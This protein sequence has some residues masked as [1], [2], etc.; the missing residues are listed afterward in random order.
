MSASDFRRIM[1]RW[2][3]GTASIALVIAALVFVTWRT[4]FPGEAPLYNEHGYALA[5]RN[6]DSTTVEYDRRFSVRYDFTGTVHR[7]VECPGQRSYDVPAITR[8]FTAGNHATQRTF[9]MDFK[10]IPDSECTLR[11]WIEHQPFG[12]LSAHTYEVKAVQFKV[13]RGRDD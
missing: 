5:Y 13:L 9:S 10:Y 8:K 6:V 12:S 11:T 4:V 7:V 2:D 1:F 3:N